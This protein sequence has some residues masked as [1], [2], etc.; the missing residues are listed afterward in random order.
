MTFVDV[1]APKGAVFVIPVES[2]V[3][4]T[5]PDLQDLVL[6]SAM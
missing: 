3:R 5:S 1:V 6:L 4:Q 2:N